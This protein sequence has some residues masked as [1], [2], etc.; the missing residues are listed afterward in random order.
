[1]S[2]IILNSIRRENAARVLEAIAR[3]KHISKREISDDTG[4][5]IRTVENIG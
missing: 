5:G 4:I 1:M 3:K 2:K